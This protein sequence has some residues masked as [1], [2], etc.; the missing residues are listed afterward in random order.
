[1]S[2]VRFWVA[3]LAAESAS[4]VSHVDLRQRPVRTNSSLVKL[5][6]ISFKHGKTVPHMGVVAMLP[7]A[8]A[9]VRTQMDE[10]QAAMLPTRIPAASGLAITSHFMHFIHSRKCIRN[11]H[12]P[13]QLLQGHTGSGNS[14]VRNATWNMLAAGHTAQT[15]HRRSPSR[16][17]KAAAAAAARATASGPTSAVPDSRPLK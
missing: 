5:N 13:L 11:Y 6:Y 12:D 7:S 1:V 9:Q 15:S 8:S 16:C 4:V 3:A 2:T 10:V 14:K 17:A